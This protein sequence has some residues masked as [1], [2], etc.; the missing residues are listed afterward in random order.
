MD[1]SSSTSSSEPDGLRP[2]GLGPLA[3]VLGLTFVALEA[4]VGLAYDAPSPMVD[5]AT[6]YADQVDGTTRDVLV[7][8]T[9][10]AEQII[11]PVLLGRQL[12]DDVVVHDLSTPAGSVLLWTLALK[13]HVPADADVALVL[14]PYGDSDLRSRMNPW[15]SQ[16]MDLAGWSDLPLLAELSCD[17]TGCVSELVLRKASRAFRYRGYLA[18]W[19]WHTLGTK[20]LSRVAGQDALSQ[21]RAGG[22]QLSP[23]ALAGAATQGLG[24]QGGADPGARQDPGGGEI[25]FDDLDVLLALARDRGWPLMFSDLPMRPD[26]RDAYWLNQ[27]RD[28]RSA[29]RDYVEAGGAHHSSLAEVPGLKRQHFTDDVHVSHEGGRLITTQL[30]RLARQALAEAPQDAS[31]D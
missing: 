10:L 17:D 29:T 11:D 8:G 1:S 15:E 18:N 7:V 14:L 20:S 21:A 9:C 31:G 5:K 12:G 26:Q 28:A 6:G 2:L 23:E 3:L 30:A 22:Q 27:R 13:N 24:W 4:G 19:V 25:R 16:V